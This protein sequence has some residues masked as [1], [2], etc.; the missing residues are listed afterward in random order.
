M[1]GENDE[2]TG[3]YLSLSKNKDEKPLIPLFYLPF[4]NSSMDEIPSIVMN[5]QEIRDNY[6][7]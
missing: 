1:E 2:V 6:L 3:S 4:L 7:R 5:A